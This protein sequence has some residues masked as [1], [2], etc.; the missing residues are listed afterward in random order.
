MEESTLVRIATE[1]LKPIS[2]F[3]D[4]LLEPT[5]MRM[6][7]RAKKR[8]LINRLEAPETN[9]VLDQYF[10]RLLRRVSGITTIVFPERAVP[11]PSIYEPQYLQEVE[12]MESLISLTENFLLQKI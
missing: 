12:H 6:R 10:K 11:L 2:S 7:R 5:L 9:E 8:E 1:A 4:A 3:I